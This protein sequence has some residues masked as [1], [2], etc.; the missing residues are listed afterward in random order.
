MIWKKLC[1]GVLATNTAQTAM[2]SEKASGEA[3]NTHNIQ[4]V[5]IIPVISIH[6]E[7][8]Q[9]QINI[10]IMIITI[11]FLLTTLKAL[12]WKQ[13]YI[14]AIAVCQCCRWYNSLRHTLMWIV[15]VTIL[16][17][18]VSVGKK[19]SL[20]RNSENSHF[21][22]TIS[23][24]LCGLAVFIHQRLYPE[25]LPEKIPLVFVTWDYMELFSISK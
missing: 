23:Y 17:G 7:A 8:N 20:W 16:H 3:Q 2:A 1:S 25:N 13:H 14:F 11:S 24:A 18:K 5:D 10:L 19:H 6:K 4:V 22:V 21:T 15:L 12:L 9:L